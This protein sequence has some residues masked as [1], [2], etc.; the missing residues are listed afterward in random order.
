MELKYARERPLFPLLMSFRGAERTAKE[1]HSTLCAMVTAQA[2]TFSAWAAYET[3]LVD[4]ETAAF[5]ASRLSAAEAAEHS[6]GESKP[7]SKKKKKR[8]LR[9][10]GSGSDEEADGGDPVAVVCEHCGGVVPEVSLRVACL[11][12]TSLDVTV[13]QRGL[14][15]EVKRLVGQVRVVVTWFVCV[16]GLAS[17]F[18]SQRCFSCADARHG[19]GLDRAL[20]RREGGRPA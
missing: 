8:K 15:R 19:P 3:V 1:V 6:D 2:A 5:F 12:G 14:V 20:R 13:A 17:A 18:D 10:D 4:P 9:D 16:F 7:P 11:D